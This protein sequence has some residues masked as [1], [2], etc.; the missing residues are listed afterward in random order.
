MGLDLYTTLMKF[1]GIKPI[2]VRLASTAIWYQV[3]VSSE[4]IEVV[5]IFNK[6]GAQKLKVAIV[7]KG[8]NPNQV[9][10]FNTTWGNF[11]VAINDY[12]M[13]PVDLEIWLQPNVNGQEV[14]VAGFSQEPFEDPRGTGYG[15]W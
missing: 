7:P 11:E 2:N 10:N 13:L 9:G 14:W 3:N 4:R 8:M 6:S 15:E 5:A 1:K 12:A